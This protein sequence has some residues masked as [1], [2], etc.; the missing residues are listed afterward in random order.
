[1]QGLSMKGLL[2]GEQPDHWRDAFFYHY[3]DQFY[4]PEHFGIRTH[5]YK[6]IKFVDSSRTAYELYDL[7]TDPK[8]L[9]NVFEDPKYSQIRETLMEKLEAE[10][11][12]FE[13]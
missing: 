5:D 10:R 4:V 2:E 8:E 13:S 1:M 9:H 11:E 7:K 3:Y 12:K 6:L